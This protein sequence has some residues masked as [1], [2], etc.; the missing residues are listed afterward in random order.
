M[1]KDASFCSIHRA[2]LQ[3]VDGFDGTY[4]EE[5][6]KESIWAGDLLSC[7]FPFAAPLFVPKSRHTPADPHRF[8]ERRIAAST[9]DR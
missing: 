6:W 5:E 4:R 9:I 1:L 8:S 3:V 7:F 2:F